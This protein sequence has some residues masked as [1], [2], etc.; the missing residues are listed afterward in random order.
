[1]T[2]IS[3][4][5]KIGFDPTRVEKSLTRRAYEGAKAKKAMSRAKA[6]EERSLKAAEDKSKL[7]KNIEK[8]DSL[9]LNPLKYR[10]NILVKAENIGVFRGGR[11]IFG[12]VSFEIM[13]G[14]QAVLCGE[15][16]CGKSTL[17]R[18]I[19]GIDDG[20]ELSGRLTVGS[21]LIISYASQNA[22]ILRGSLNEYADSIGVDLTLFL[23]ILRKLGFDREQFEKNLEEL[24]AGQ[25]K[26]ALLAGSLASQAH[27]YIWD[28]PLNF[29][30]VISRIQIEELIKQFRPTMLFAEHDRAF[31]EAVGAEEIHLG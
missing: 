27:L 8:C 29:I 11:E 19:C 17:L 13:E 2:D 3:E 16:G 7:L 20:A 25:R 10:G 22:D 28:E 26:K 12:N 4:R 30:D 18:L 5:K 9:K 23:T 15:N 31:R 24:S 1:M 14:R 21:G 6:F